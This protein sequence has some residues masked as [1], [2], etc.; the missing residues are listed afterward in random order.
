M[1]LKKIL[2]GYPQRSADN[3][4]KMIQPYDMVSFDV[5]DT[6]LKRD[7]ESESDVFDLVERKY[8]STHDKKIDGLK[9]FARKLNLKPERR[10]FQRKSLL[11]IYI[12]V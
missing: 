6:L 8:N 7:V 11:T 2:N 3:I 9:S 10:M 5:F 4:I 1:D 12:R